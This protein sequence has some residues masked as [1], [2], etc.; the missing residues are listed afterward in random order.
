M[1]SSEKNKLKNNS[2]IYDENNNKSYSKTLYILIIIQISLLLYSIVFGKAIWN[3]ISE[4]IC[5]LKGNIQKQNNNN[6]I[7]FE[8]IKEKFNEVEKEKYFNKQNYFCQNSGLFNNSSFEEKIEVAN[9]KYNNLTFNMYVYKKGDTVSEIISKYGSWEIVETKFLLL[10][11]DYYYNKT[12]I[13]KKDIYILD[14]GA[15]IGWYSLVLGIQG[16]NVLSFEPSRRNYYILLKNYCLNQNINLIIINKGLDTESKNCTLYHPL[17]NIGNAIIYYNLNESKKQNYEEEK[18]ILTRLSNYVE[19]LTSKN[20]ALIKLD[21]EGS[22]GKAIEGGIDLI[23]KYHVPFIFIEWTPR[24]L[25]LKGTDPKL[26]LQIFEN[27]GYKISTKDFLSKQY[28]HIEELLNVHK[29][30]IYIV[31]T[32]FLE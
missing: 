27:N 9:A 15:N 8:N 28:C 7:L 24:Q 31:Y 26:F 13:S 17:D 14:I 20:V 18:I 3:K 21:V 23:V 30:N 11:L 2:Y 16:Y 12:N 22:E 4:I 6:A 25:I 1:E 10:S 32:K 19:F 5:F 29:I